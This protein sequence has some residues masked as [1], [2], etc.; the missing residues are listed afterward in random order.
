MFSFIFRVTKGRDHRKRIEAEIFEILR[1]TRHWQ[2]NK[3][4]ILCWKFVNAVQWCGF[5]LFFTKPHKILPFSNG[6]LANK[7]TTA[8]GSVV[9]VCLML[10]IV[11]L[12]KK[13]L[14]LLPAVWLQNY[15]GTPSNYKVN[16]TG[17]GWPR[18]YH[19]WW[20]AKKIGLADVTVNVVSDVSLKYSY[21][22]IYLNSVGTWLYSLSKSIF[23]DKHWKM[24]L[25]SKLTNK[26]TSPINLK[27]FRLVYG[28]WIEATS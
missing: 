4:T 2:L 14:A 9:S 28:G 21:D 5:F 3:N 11:F 18:V 26:E 15:S 16:K 27:Q 19:I 13:H 17:T 7:A 12:A 22:I 8:Y 6:K 1:K 24:L 23:V 10:L 25:W 20:C